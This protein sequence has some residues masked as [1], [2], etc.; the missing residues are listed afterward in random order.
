MYRKIRSVQGTSK[1]GLTHLLVPADSDGDPKTCTE[2]VSV[3]LPCD[4]ETH[5]RARES[6]VPVF[7]EEIQNE[8]A[9]A[10]RKPYTKQDFDATSCYDRIIPWMASMLS[11]SHGLHQ[12]VCLVHAQTLQEARYL[13]KTNHSMLRP[14]IGEADE[15]VWRVI[16]PLF[17]L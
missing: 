7:I 11:C 13:L 2:W 10:S 17:H 12:N 3:D 6:L 5:L 15:M 9:R 4:I 8:I 16:P 1:Q 14:S